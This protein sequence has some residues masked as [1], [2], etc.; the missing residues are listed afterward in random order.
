MGPVRIH[1]SHPGSLKEF[2]YTPSAPAPSRHRALAA[3]ARML[4][5]GD[6]VH[7]LNALAV[8]TKTTQPH[9]HY[10]YLADM[11]FVHT[12]R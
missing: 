3:A 4:G 5:R 6:V 12:L 7:K 8:L 10:I 9:N 11:K 1:L 2:G